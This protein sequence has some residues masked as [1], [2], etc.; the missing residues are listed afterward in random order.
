MGNGDTAI[1]G[2]TPING[3]R[4]NR[5]SIECKV[6]PPI[7]WLDTVMMSEGTNLELL[8]LDN[9]RLQCGM[10]CKVET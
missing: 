4:G 3:I 5:P 6:D 2:D 1:N 10:R 9:T 8:M 7:V